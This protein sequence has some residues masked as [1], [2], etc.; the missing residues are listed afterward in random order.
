MGMPMASR[1]AAANLLA[2]VHN[3]TRAS[4]D[5][6]GAAAGVRS[7]ATP[8]E[9]AD[10]SNVIV[11]MLAD[12]TASHSLFVG[13]GGF[14]EGLRPAT[15][16]IEMATVSLEHLTRIASLVE[17]IGCSLIDAPVS[18]SVSMARDGSLSILVGGDAAVLER[19]RPALASMGSRI[20]HLGGLGAGSAMK[21]AVNT[22][23]YALNQGISEG[24]VLA[25]RAGVERRVAY[26]VFANS[27]VAAPFVHYRREQFER[28][29]DL[30]PALALRLA[31]KDLRLILR[32]A[33]SV[34]LELPQ[35]EADLESLDEA[36][37]AGFAEADVS[38]VA[39][40]LRQSGENET[41]T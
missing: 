41:V 7:F 17:P 29:G 27:A 1:L 26:E 9:L 35:A 23:V 28:P 3:R 32:L 33:A 8:A 20:F 13:A 39:E 24:L 30:E 19:V 18:G 22:V 21:L 37:S 5:A 36:M 15:V 14:L 25:E 2:G 31:A 10:A 11:T 34:N 6:F 38:A 4:A 16:V 40:L 12:E